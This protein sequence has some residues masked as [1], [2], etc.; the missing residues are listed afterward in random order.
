MVTLEYTK[1]IIDTGLSKVQ[2]VVYEVLLK[3]G[4]SPASTIT[5]AIPRDMTISRPLV[6]RALEELIELELASKLDVT[7]KVARFIPK[8]PVAITKVIDAQRERIER[9]KKQFITTQGKLSSLFNL[10][11]GKPGVQFYEGED[12]VWEVLMDSLTASEEILA[13]SDL[14]AIR[15]YIPELN[16]E[17]ATLREEKGVKKRALVIDSPETRKFL[18][19]YNPTYTKQKLIKTAEGVTAFQ[20]TVQ[21]YDNKISYITLTDE[22]FVGIIVTDQHIADTQRFLFESLWNLSGGEIL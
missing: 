10:T 15:K 14:D 8:H 2:A 1:D 21:I 4:E 19:S 6:Y 9:T 18:Q 7:G 13:Y 16:A 20:T 3:L 12:G 11:V 5:K 22:Y 17:Y